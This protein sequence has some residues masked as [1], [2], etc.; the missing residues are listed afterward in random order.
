[1]VVVE[2]LMLCVVVGVTVLLLLAIL[3]SHQPIVPAYHS[4]HWTEISPA[5]MSEERIEDFNEQLPSQ[6][7]P[8]RDD[9]WRAVYD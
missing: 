4:A 6:R 7:T 1:M 2:M 5:N 9:V 3:G 8:L